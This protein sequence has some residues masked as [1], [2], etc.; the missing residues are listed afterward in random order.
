MESVKSKSILVLKPDQIQ[1]KDT[2]MAFTLIC[3]IICLITGSKNWLFAGSILLL[4]DMLYSRFFFI[5]AILWFTFANIL[6]W[7]SSKVLLTLI[8]FIVITPIGLIR[9]LLRNLGFGKKSKG[10]DSLKLKQWKKSKE[11]V[12]NTRNYRF[13]KKDLLKPY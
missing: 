2:G 10:F 9:K 5:P 11:S 8:F 6:G 12:F 1:M 3:L 13:S 7:I 4:L